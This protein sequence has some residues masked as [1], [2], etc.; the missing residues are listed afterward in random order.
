RD[1]LHET[2][3]IRGI[4]VE[5]VDTAG[6]RQTEDAVERIGVDRA[7]EAARSADMVLYVFDAGLGWTEE[8]GGA[9]SALNGAV[10]AIVAN[11]IDL[12]AEASGGPEGAVPLCAIAA[13]AG[14]QL[15]ALL[16]DA[17]TQDLT[18]EAA[19]E[20]LS[21]LRQRDLVARA[22][23]AA[24]QAVDALSRGES[25][26]YAATH[27][28]AALDALADLAGETTPEDVLERI[29]STFCIGK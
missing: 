3:D 19:S 12:A 25:P 24:G 10:C 2:L 18:T 13:G 16:E 6:L 8:D 15:R 7:R 23:Q 29:F 4:P 14:G 11:K 1:T 22:R 20:V 27:L 21:S 17:L 28:D 5:L 9:L 26:E